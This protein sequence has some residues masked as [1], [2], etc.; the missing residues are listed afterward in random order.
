MIK[1]IRPYLYILPAFIFV[2]FFLLMPMVKTLWFSFTDYR[3]LVKPNF[4]GLQNYIR[5]FHDPAF[6]RSLIN[7][8]IWVIAT[9]AMPVSGGLIIAVVVTRVK[10]AAFYKSIIFIPLTISAV[11]TGIIWYWMLSP[12]LGVVNTIL[13]IA[14]LD[15][16]KRSW[17][18][19]Y[20]LNTITMIIVWTWQTTGT[21]MVLFLMGLTALP[22]EPIEAAKI[23]GASGFKIFFRVIFP[24]LR[25]ITT[26]VIGIAI[27]NSFKV[28]DLIYVMTGGG[29]ARSSEVLAVSMF[30]ESFTNFRMGY[31][32]AI[33]ILLSIMIIA[34]SFLYVHQMALKSSK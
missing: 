23:D 29:P 34:V 12:N 6:F 22:E 26:I 32:A 28:F 9:L 31:G 5:F 13:R 27:I 16:L 2:G 15:F 20:P 8:F 24:M 19:N 21:N 1:K 18:I 14:G 11:T 25:P 30:R 10:F 33:S 3:G 17:L 4:I 7:T